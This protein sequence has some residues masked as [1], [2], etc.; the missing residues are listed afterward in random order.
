MVNLEVPAA[1]KVGDATFRPSRWRAESYP[2]T[3]HPM[4][5][6]AACLW[7]YADAWSK[8]TPALEQPYATVEVRTRPREQICSPPTKA[9][10]RTLDEARERARDAIAVLRLYQRARY[11][12]VDNEIQTFGLVGDIGAEPAIH[13]TVG[14]GGPPLMGGRWHGVIAQWTSSQRTSRPSDD[15]GSNTSTGYSRRHPISK[16]ACSSGVLQALRAWNARPSW[17]RA[18]AHRP[19]GGIARGIDGRPQGQRRRDGA[20]GASGVAASRLPETCLCGLW[21]HRACVLVSRVEDHE[22]L[23][24]MGQEA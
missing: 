8:K 24:R 2:S 16:R 4:P 10:A 20:E 1:W 3:E 12:P 7:S 11:I 21:S 5:T 14:R 19:R 15:L 17:S 22:G 23:S 18:P 9:R 6:V 13:W